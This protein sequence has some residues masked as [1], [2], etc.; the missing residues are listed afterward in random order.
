MISVMT[1]I[2]IHPT[3]LH[4]T[5]T[6]REK[7]VGLVRDQEIPRSAVR[8]V[9]VVPDGVDAA[10]GVRAPGFAF[11]GR[12]SIGTWR[13]RGG[14]ALVAV[15]GGRPAVRIAL[16]GQRY[17]ELLLDVDDPGAVAHALAPASR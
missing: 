11:P 7:I 14:R 6:T 5:F 17:S 13:T 10:R 12:R 4:V 16:E 9:E 1:T 2:S 8:G 3:S 15:H